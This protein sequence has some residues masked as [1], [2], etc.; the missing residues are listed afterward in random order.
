MYIKNIEVYEMITLKDLTVSYQDTLAL[1]PL[2]LTIKE[3]TITGIIGPNGAGKST[4]L[5]GMLGIIDHQGQTLL[6][7]KP[8]QNSLQ[9]VAYVEQKINIDYH[10]P[11]KVKE[12][13]SLG[14]YPQLKLFQGLKSSHWDKVAEALKIV[15]L[16][17]LAERQISQLS[18]GQFQR[19]L[20]ARCLVQEA[21]CIFL[22][23]PFVGI[24]SVSEEIIMSTLRSLKAAG[25]IILIVHHDL[26]KVVD[27]FDQV[28]LLNRKLIAFGPTETSFTKDNMKKTYGSQLFMN[29]GA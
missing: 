27:Y 15:G 10:F 6:D 23:E 4:L 3:P 24:D 5:K 11:I 29:G 25:K 18:G 2:S 1:E 16:E 26:S 13:V 17:D 8:L 20:I 28:I 7:Q 21:D 9:R 22:D 14:L 12:C 19:V